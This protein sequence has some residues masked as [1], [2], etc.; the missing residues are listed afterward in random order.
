VS[1]GGF[2]I[3]SILYHIYTYLSRVFVKKIL[4]FL[5]FAACLV[6]GSPGLLASWS[7][8]LLASWSPGL[9][10]SW[11]PGPTGGGYAAAPAG[12]VRCLTT[13]KKEKGAKLQKPLDNYNNMCYNIFVIKRRR[14]I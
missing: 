8:G 6:S 5:Y 4:D 10:I 14:E 2:F 3:V 11:S 13:E 9:L 1:L 12:P 7:P